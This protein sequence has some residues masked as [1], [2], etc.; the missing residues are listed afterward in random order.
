MPQYFIRKHAVR[1]LSTKG[2]YIKFNTKIS[3]LVYSR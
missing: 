1:A 2:V 3:S